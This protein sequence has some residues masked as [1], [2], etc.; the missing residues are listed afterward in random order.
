MRGNETAPMKST[1]SFLLAVLIW[2]FMPVMLAL[3]SCAP[4]AVPSGMIPTAP[5]VVAAAAPKAAAVQQ[6]SQTNAV[7]TA[8]LTGQVETLRAA[9]ADL[10]SR[11][12]EALAEADRL[13]KQ[14]ATTQAQ[15]E[16]LWQTLNEA[17][18]R[19]LFVESAFAE[20]KTIIN[21]Q[22]SAQRQQDES[23]KV[24]IASADEKDAEAATLRAQ[25]TDMGVTITAQQKY[26]TALTAEN[27][28]SQRDAAV[29]SFLK[30][31]AVGASIAVF[32]ALCGLVYLKS[33]IP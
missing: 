13:R 2:L 18:T 14:P 10:S 21:D 12:T 22:Q 6:A 32:L 9:S 27:L 31:Y 19:N 30:W 4:R 7:A 11:L 23:I 1:T 33:L 26:I 25:H 5:A 8:R 28:K 29:G 15:V 20:A 24:M 3:T 16:K 17:Q